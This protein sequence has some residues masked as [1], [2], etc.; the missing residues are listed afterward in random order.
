MFS[1]QLI[2]FKS[3]CRTILYILMAVLFGKSMDY[4]FLHHHLSQ[5]INVRILGSCLFSQFGGFIRLVGL[6]YFYHKTSNNISCR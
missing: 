6:N 3:P 1:T 5:P 4:S 2:E